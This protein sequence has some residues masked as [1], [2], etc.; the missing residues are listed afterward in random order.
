[1]KV[2]PVALLALLGFGFA[3]PA[4]AQ[5]NTTNDFL[6]PLPA[7]KQW[8][9]IWHDEFDSG[10]LDGSKWNRL[11]DWKRRD[12]FWVK[13]DAY[14]SGKGTLLLRARKDGDR[15]TCGD[16]NTQG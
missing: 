6:P 4:S 1:M 8:K 16:V 13:D 9:L 7:G 15:F 12:G 11:G 14:L 3:S 5:N 2:R 10:T